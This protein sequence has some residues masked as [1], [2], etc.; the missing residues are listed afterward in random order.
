MPERLAAI[1]DESLYWGELAVDTVVPGKFFIPYSEGIRTSNT[2]HGTV[3]LY[4][5]VADR[6]ARTVNARM[7]L[8]LGP[9]D[10]PL[11]VEETLSAPGRIV[12]VHWLSKGEFP[13]PYRD[14][15]YVHPLFRLRAMPDGQH[16]CFI[17]KGFTPDY[18]AVVAARLAA[19][20]G[21]LRSEQEEHFRAAVGDA[22]GYGR[23]R[24]FSTVAP[25]TGGADALRTYIG[26]G[27]ADLA[28]SALP[29]LFK[30]AAL[31]I[32]AQKAPRQALASDAL[33]FAGTETG[34]AV[35]AYETLQSE[36]DSRFIVE[37]RELEGRKGK[38]CLEVGD[39]EYAVD[40]ALQSA[41]SALQSQSAG[42]RRRRR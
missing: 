6:P 29:T 41:R 42:P 26:T 11:D 9:D 15:I 33:A 16:R 24:E 32:L 10:S 34:V 23:L 30:E 39:V 27:I 7:S 3:T 5:R 40:M 14:T 18:D 22:V 19:L 38:G 31:A 17:Q 37:L 12:P 35:S 13:E 4:G 36:F 2:S 1:G 8:R 25:P 20:P 28:S 21:E